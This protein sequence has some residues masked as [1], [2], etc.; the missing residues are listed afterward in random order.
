MGKFF[1]STTIGENFSLVDIRGKFFPRPIKFLQR[2]KIF[3]HFPLSDRGKIFPR[4]IKLVWGCWGLLEGCQSLSED[5]GLR[6]INKMLLFDHRNDST[7]SNLIVAAELLRV[8]SLLDVMPQYVSS[9]TAV[10][11]LL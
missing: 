10:F 2:G 7:S 5:R 1:P 8:S 6:I 9:A 11:A 3:P 4:P